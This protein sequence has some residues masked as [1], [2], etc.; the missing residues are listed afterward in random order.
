[1]G[2]CHEPLRISGVADAVATA[3]GLRGRFPHAHGAAMLDG[4]GVVLD[5][6]VFTRHNHSI[7]DALGWAGCFMANH[8]RAKRIVL[9]SAVESGVG[10]E[11]READLETLRSARRRFGE[12]GVLVI[13][14]LQCDGHQ[15]RSLDFAADGEGWRQASSV[16]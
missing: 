7:S 3:F 8:G 9:L 1:M 11:L 2:R 12:A 13:D 14:W 6:T 4:D 10:D 15:V 16:A 5:L